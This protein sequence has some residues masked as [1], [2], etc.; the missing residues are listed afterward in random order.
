MTIRVRSYAVVGNEKK[1]NDGPRKLSDE[2]AATTSDGGE[3]RYTGGCSRD[4]GKG[5]A[6]R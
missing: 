6:S 3:L 5:V 1:K 2:G 4:S